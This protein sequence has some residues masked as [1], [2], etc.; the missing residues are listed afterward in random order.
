MR[1]DQF[2][3]QKQNISR[4][5]ASDLIKLGF[6]RVDQKIILKPSFKITSNQEVVVNDIMKYV[7]RS[8]LK[9]EDAI[10]TYDL[11][12]NNKTVVDIGSST[13]GF[14]QCSLAFG[15]SKVYAY[16]VGTDQMD[17][18]LKK[19]KRIELYEQTNILDVLVKE[20]DICL[21]DVSFTSVKPILKHVY[22]KCNLFVIL[23]KPQFEVGPNHLYGGIVKSDK[24]IEKALN[25]FKVFLNELNIIIEGYKPSDL[26]GK[27]GNQEYLFVG[28]RYVKEN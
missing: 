21:I 6:V 17:Q 18:T 9:L 19:D 25:E 22:E 23:F 2:V 11:D 13:G 14:T 15:A 28:K 16:D 7:S 27:K 3:S 10:I 24:I 1:L 8:G 12:F 26:K 20:V 5:K 4:S